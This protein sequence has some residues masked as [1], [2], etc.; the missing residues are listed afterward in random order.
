VEV[1]DGNGG[2]DTVTVD[3]TIDPVNDAPVIE[4]VAGD[5]LFENAAPGTLVASL[6]LSD[7]DSDIL[8][9]S[10][11]LLDDAGGRFA[12]DGTDI[13]VANGLLLDYEQA[14]SHDI[15]VAVT[16]AE[17]AVSVR[18][19]TIELNDVVSE[20]VTG[21]DGGDLI[22]AGLEGDDTLN[23]GAGAD[24]MAGGPG[25]DTYIVDSYGDQVVELA[26]EGVDTI[27]TNL[28]A[29][30]IFSQVNIENLTGTSGG[31]QTLTGNAGDNVIVGG[32]G[33]TT[34][35][36][37][38][39]ND[40]VLGGDGNDMLD[41]GSGDDVLIGG[42]GNDTLLGG[43]GADTFVFDLAPGLGGIDTIADFTQ[44]T[45]LIGLSAT[46]FADLQAAGEIDLAGG[47]L[48]YD[49]GTGVLSYDADGAGGP[50]TAVAFAQFAPAFRP[51]T[52]DG[53]DFLFV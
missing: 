35:F 28:S 14:T 17:G 44:G 12:L 33:A 29:Y 24:T 8:A 41:G 15:A 30:S 3:V 51:L 40:T 19:I 45:D 13:I 26:D 21:G 25:N 48:S 42:A 38:G 22:L 1:S 32:A 43:G 27:E 50:G 18:L 11:V 5:P 36:A 20:T 53:D 7:V 16:D 39:G 37:S 9:A 6:D 10:V 4:L 47:W 46:V 23:G 34:V 31:A 2:F 49:A 52:L